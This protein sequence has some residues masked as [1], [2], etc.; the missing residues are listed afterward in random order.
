MFKAEE[1]EV[2]TPDNYNAISLLTGDVCKPFQAVVEIKKLESSNEKDSKAF[3]LQ[4]KVRRVSLNRESLN[5]K[6]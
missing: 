1:A 2:E 4:S 5:K 3:D 6:D